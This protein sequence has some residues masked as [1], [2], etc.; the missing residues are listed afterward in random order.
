MGNCRGKSWKDIESQFETKRGLEDIVL[1][2][3]QFPISNFEPYQHQEFL[4]HD[5]I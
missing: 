2:F 1:Q 5:K 3:M 4:K